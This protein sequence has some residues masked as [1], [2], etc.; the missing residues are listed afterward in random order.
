MDKR[1]NLVGTADTQKNDVYKSGIWPNVVA[2]SS[3]T[4][5]V[6]AKDSNNNIFSFC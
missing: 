2:M 5:N 6:Q 1:R 3:Y 4:L